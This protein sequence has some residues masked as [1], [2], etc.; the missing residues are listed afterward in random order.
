MPGASEVF[1][2]LLAAAAE[3]RLLL[4]VIPCQR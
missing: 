3:L 1:K 4:Q 2:S